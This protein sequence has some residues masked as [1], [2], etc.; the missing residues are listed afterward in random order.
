VASV[1][2]VESTEQKEYSHQAEQFCLRPNAK[3]KVHV[4]DTCPNGMGLWKKLLKNTNCALGLFHFMNRILK[5]LRKE[6]KDFKAATASL[7]ESIYYLDPGDLEKVEQCIRKGLLAKGAN[8]IKCPDANVK[9]KA[10]TYRGNIRIWTYDKETISNRLQGWLNL[11][12][13]NVDDNI[14][15]PLFTEETIKSVGEQLTKVKWI[16]DLLSKDELY[17]EVKPGIRSKTGL[18]TYIGARGVESKLEKGHHSIAHFANGGMRR[19]FADFLGMAGIALYNLRIRYRLKVAELEPKERVKIPS[20]FQNAPAFTNHL[21]LSYINKLAEQSGFKKTVHDEVEILHPDNGERFF[22]EYLMQ[23][24]ERANQ[25][26]EYDEKLNRCLCMLCGK[27]NP[28]AKIHRW[29]TQQDLL[30]AAV[31][32][33]IALDADSNQVMPPPPPAPPVPLPTLLPAPHP[34]MPMQQPF[35]LSAAYH[36][37]I[38]V[39]RSHGPYSAL[40]KEKGTK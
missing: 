35:F 40:M 24:R 22:S 5:T 33:T 15:L 21:R 19:S 1:A 29:S 7:Q 8:G 30:A 9:S 6:H 38:P 2:I 4:L 32:T 11:W 17:Y 36:H 27:R 3:S 13:D 39:L 23:Q 28:Y 12:V 26:I 34:W 31:S 14:G 20:A 18:S 16:V 25:K 10:R 37:P